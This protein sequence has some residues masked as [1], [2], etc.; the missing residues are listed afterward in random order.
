MNFNNFIYIFSFFNG[1]RTRKVTEGKHFFFIN[2]SGLSWHLRERRYLLMTRKGPVEY[3]FN[4]KH[5]LVCFSVFV[6]GLCSSLSIFTTFIIN[7]IKDDLVS[8]ASA[9]PIIIADFIDYR[10]LETRKL[11]TSL[12]ELKQK[13]NITFDRNN[14]IKNLKYTYY[15]GENLKNKNFFS[16]NPMNDLSLKT[17]NLSVK[18]FRTT[19]KPDISFYSA[20]LQPSISIKNLNIN[21]IKNSSFFN[22][23]SYKSSNFKFESE[24]NNLS[25]LISWFKFPDII[26]QNKGLV[27]KDVI[28][29]K[30]LE[31]FSSLMKEN[32]K[33]NG[34]IKPK[35][36]SINPAQMP[37]EAEAY[38]I[39][40][41][42]D[43]E[44]SQF[45]EL[46]KTLSIN[47]GEELFQKIEVVLE[48][49][50]LVSPDSPIFF[51]QLTDR[52]SLTKDLRLALNF[53]PLKA[54]MDY[55]YI[56][57]KFGMRKDP[58]TKQKRFHRGIDL[59][60]TWHED[61]LA[62]A[63]GIVI[64]AGGNGGYG[65]MIKIQHRYGIVTAYGHLQKVLVKK[66]QKVNI[67]TRIGKMGSTGRSTGQHLHYEI[68]VNKK[69]INPGIFIK[70]GKKL[71][72]RNILQATSR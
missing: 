29:K 11:E 55:Y 18:N 16:F 65:K 59:A 31:Q 4:L 67:G 3:V 24:A 1:L 2:Y 60:G 53:I 20:L 8:S 45:D 43:N 33:N 36:F 70:E 12:S 46:L 9:T 32:A 49:R 5:Y 54:P 35:E 64:F 72:T 13:S 56:S 27:V 14:L 34:L 66:G 41:G 58:K 26:N 38:R 57:S 17:S 62:P 40:S 50:D 44:I 25:N 47:V 61:V 21:K 28:G 23:D 63:D 69:Y 37:P 7:V 6:F 15:R 42:F 68:I 39:L 22:S 19:I 30:E 71:L 48:K 51:K 10:A 52:V